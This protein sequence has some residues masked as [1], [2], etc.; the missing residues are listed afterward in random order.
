MSNL[1]G[2]ST[3]TPL[4]QQRYDFLFP[5][6]GPHAEP[7]VRNLYGKGKCS[8]SSFLEKMAQVCDAKSNKKEYFEALYE[9]F[10]LGEIYSSGE[11]IG[12]VNEVRRDL[13]LSLYTE[14]I[15][16]QSEYDFNLVFVVQDMYEP[17]EDSVKKTITGYMP[18]AKVLPE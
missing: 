4:Q 9:V 18:V 6:Y 15:K 16:I 7:I 13:G 14:K 8:W 10:S 12:A 3:L 11:I 17:R 2:K 5:T 1:D